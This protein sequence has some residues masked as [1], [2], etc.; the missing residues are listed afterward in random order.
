MTVGTFAAALG[1]DLACGE[2]PAI[3]HPTVWVGRAAAALERP[4]LRLSPTGQF[5]AGAAVGFGLPALAAVL[6]RALTRRLSR[7]PRPAF[8]RTLVPVWLLKSAFS[9]RMLVREAEL[10]ADRLDR[11]ELD[12]AR[13]RL[14]SLVSRETGELDPAHVASAAIESLAENVTDS[15]VAPW[16]YAAAGGVPAALAYR[17]VNTLDSMWGYHGNYEHFG[18]IPARL[19]DALN[20]LPAR[21]SAALI[22]LAAGRRAR[23]AWTTARREH[24]RTES[25][26]AGWTMAAAA[27][28][29]GVWL[30]KPGAY[31]L[32]RGADPDPEAI[33]R[34]ARLVT[35]TAVIAALLTAAAMTAR[36]RRGR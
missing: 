23:D 32:G 34:A 10:V 6:S 21:L 36:E 3:L 27:G 22:S 11:G 12:A 16:C 1:W 25:P 17:V 30:E 13:W 28:A 5:V 2:P 8:L 14:R 20:F 29:L 15:F 26:N 18:K 9:V 4:A 24:A 19:D 7:S 33:R 35:R 31:R